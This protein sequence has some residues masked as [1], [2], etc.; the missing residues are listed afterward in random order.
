MLFKFP[1]TIMYGQV[2]ACDYLSKDIGL[3]WAEDHYR[4][5]FAW[6]P[7]MASFAVPDHD[8]ECLVEVETEGN[9][10]LPGSSALW[11]IEVP[12]E[13]KH[14]N[15]LVGTIL[16]EE[17]ISI[18]NGQYRLIFSASSGQTADKKNYAYILR[19]DF[20]LSVNAEFRILQRSEFPFSDHVLRSSA[21][22]FGAPR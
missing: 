12:F 19:F 6:D 18:P 22:R 4:Q 9:I 17:E 8:G 13:V 1:L 7:E 20:V 14:G 5:G 10:D 16:F 11:A 21:E 15:I 2:F 3:L